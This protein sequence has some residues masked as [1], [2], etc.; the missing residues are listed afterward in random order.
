M[1]ERLGARGRLVEIDVARALAAVAVVALHA[2]GYGLTRDPAG[3][4][5]QHLDQTLV[6]AL[7][8]VRQVFM[9]ISG[10]A[11][12]YAYRDREI[13]PRTF[14]TRRMWRVGLPYLAWSAIY[15]LVAPPDGVSLLGAVLFGTAFYHLYYVVVSLQWYVVFPTILAWTRRLSPRRALASA[16]CGTLLSLGL[17][18][19]LTAGAP[20]PNW[21]SPLNAVL[22]HRDQLLLSYIGHYLVG[23]LAG[24]HAEAVLGW[25]RR[26]R[27]G[28]GAVMAGLLGYLALDLQQEPFARAVDIFRPGLVL[29]GLVGAFMVLACAGEI[30]RAGGRAF[31]WLMAL[32]R[33]SYAIYL[34]H[35]LAL[36]LL[37][38]YVLSHV[39]NYSPILSI[40]LIAA[41]VLMPHGLALLLNASPLAPLLLGR[42]SWQN[43]F[44]AVSAWADRLHRHSVAG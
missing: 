43:P 28:V 29:Y 34:A 6:L 1:Q 15:L 16:A 37:E 31:D 39:H 30:T 35:P 23:T 42:G 11:M 24:V 22:A 33:N 14:I 13:D 27:W 38:S 19:W 26:R 36:Y 18:S 7:R 12:A 5:A 40:P 9:F 2:I 8:F 17:A 32:S 10:F 41:A 20:V 44:P 25:L 4:A 21:A 3:S